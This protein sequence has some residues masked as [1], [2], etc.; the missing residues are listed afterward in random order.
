MKYQVV[1]LLVF[2]LVCNVTAGGDKAA[3]KELKKLEGTW[4]L[5]SGEQN[6]KELSK[7]ALKGA[8]LVIVGNKHTVNL[9]DETIVGTHSLDPSTK[10]KSI[11]ADNVGK[12]HL[13]IY[14]IKGDEFKVCFAEPGKYRPKEFTAKEGSGN[15]VHVWKR[16]K[17]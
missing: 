9:G 10:P 6:G 8:K 2:A 1:M 12:K 5:V 16:V 15:F 13:G 4:A 14:E 11:D 7:E 17:K 3:K